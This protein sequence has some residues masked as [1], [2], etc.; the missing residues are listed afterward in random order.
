MR[1]SNAAALILISSATGLVGLGAGYWAAKKR[2]DEEFDSR[3]E[4]ETEKIRGF[5]KVPEQEFST[6][7][8]A[9][10]KLIV[11]TQ[12]Q[13]DK[14]EETVARE[15]VAYDKI[16]P[17][18]IT[19]E[20]EVQNVFRQ[21]PPENC[22]EQERIRVVSREEFEENENGWDTTTL[23]WYRR[24]DVLCGPDEEPINDVIGHLGTEFR[25]KFGMDSNDP[26]TICII[27]ETLEIGFEVVM[28]LSSYQEEV[29]GEDF[30]PEEPLTSGRER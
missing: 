12:D 11:P 5:Y 13:V 17:A 2:F 30:V 20:V 26:H 15:R 27:N 28:H 29:L 21:T 22:V 19:E 7:E 16:V 9:V 23:T 18:L 24:D 8:E 14:I 10:E 25:E 6:P 1:I 3:L 4:I